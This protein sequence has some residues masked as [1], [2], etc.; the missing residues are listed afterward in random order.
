MF[1]FTLHV[2]FHKMFCLHAF[3]CKEKVLNVHK[4]REYT[5]KKVNT[6]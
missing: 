4:A 6:F 5:K 2:P 1:F 3:G